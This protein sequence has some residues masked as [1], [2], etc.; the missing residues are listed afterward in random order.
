MHMKLHIR[1]RIPNSILV[2]T[3]GS[4]TLMYTIELY[5]FFL[6]ITDNTCAEIVCLQFAST[7]IMYSSVELLR[8]LNKLN[9][10]ADNEYSVQIWPALTCHLLCIQ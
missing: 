8:Y 6:E 2:D 7:Q 4:F 1:L 5:Y 9:K 10:H 3:Q